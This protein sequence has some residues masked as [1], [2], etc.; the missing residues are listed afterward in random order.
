MATKQFR[1]PRPVWA[2]VGTALF[3][4]AVLTGIGLTSRRG[5]AEIAERAIVTLRASEMVDSIG[6]NTHLA[7]T[8]SRYADAG[9][10]IEALR[11]IGVGRV[12]DAIPN[13]S[14]PGNGWYNY[15]PVAGAGIAFDLVAGGNDVEIDKT[16]ARIE[17]LEKQF[18]GA[19]AS[20]EGP[21][22]Y[23]NWPFEFAGSKGND[24][25]VAFQNAL[26]ARLRTTPLL[27]HVPLYNLTTWPPAFG[28]YDLLSIHIYPKNGEQ[29]R[30]TFAYEI[31]KFSHD[32]KFFPAAL[33]EIGFYTLQK[34]IGWGG[35]DAITQ[36][37]LTLNTLLI[38]KQIG[39]STTYLYELLDAYPDPAET[40]VERHF[41]L[42]TADYAPKPAAE[43]LRRLTAA[44]ADPGPNR[45]SFT[46]DAHRVT[47][48]AEDD[49]IASLAFR[50]STGETV[51]LLWDE[52]EIWNADTLT[53]RQ[54][55]DLPVRLA[56]D[57]PRRI[58]SVTDAITGEA[59]DKPG[60][61]SDSLG[62]TMR[63]NP[64]LIVT[65]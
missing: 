16:I 17:Q 42:F 29:P 53:P 9:K 45:R 39:F 27:K 60:N 6:V 20:V 47:L 14:I 50:K 23:N 18:P 15:P 25:A 48:R 43:A 26:D 19:I 36:A 40:E 4:G 31:K 44:L 3:L 63:G 32:G 22:E 46:P 61:A 52:R 12:R 24:A 21:N 7:Y 54:S 30:S 65:Q 33:T 28:R 34:K 49:R 58:L 2:L 38:A 51:F 59:L 37:R 41:G 8:D 5:N 55:A 64:V 62:V 10:V 13:A 35:V 56:F 57:G 1:F 11:Y